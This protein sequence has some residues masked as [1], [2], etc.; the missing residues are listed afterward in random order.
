MRCFV[1][2]LCAG[3][4]SAATISGKLSPPE[5]V[6]E[7]KPI[8]R[9]P[10]DFMTMRD[11]YLPGKYDPKTGKFEAAAPGDGKYDLLIITDT[12]AK[13][14]GIDLHV[15]EETDQGTGE[16]ETLFDYVIETKKFTVKNLDTSKFLEEGQ[17]VTEQEK[18]DLTRRYLHFEKLLERINDVCKVSRFENKIRA[19]YVHGMR[20]HARVF[21]EMGRD[22]AFYNSGDKVTWRVEIWDFLWKG[23]V[24]DNPNKMQLTV[25][26]AKIPVMDFR[27]MTWV[28]DPR[29]GAIEVV[30]GAD[31]TE[32]NY[33]L[34][35]PLTSAMGKVSTN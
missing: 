28:F 13:I 35:D 3:S 5:K 20:K 10:A 15:A 9:I 11:Q 24:W 25:E 31:V 1:L 7:V 14:E 12:G 4:L 21:I 33:R 27:K 19:L 32:F 23:D 8:K 34:P 18:D 6:K 2:I 26:R 30:G 29:L 17:E 22:K 16:E